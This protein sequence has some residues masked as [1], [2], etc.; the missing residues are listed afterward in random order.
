MLSRF[1]QSPRADVT[2]APGV[3]VIVVAP[4]TPAT[5]DVLPTVT[6]GGVIVAVAVFTDGVIVLPRGQSSQLFR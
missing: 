5:T 3:T 4:H 6:T 2:A 1:V